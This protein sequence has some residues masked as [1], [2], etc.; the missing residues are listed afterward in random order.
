MKTTCTHP[1]TTIIVLDA[2][3][4]HEI[5]GYKCTECKDIVKTEKS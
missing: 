4:M 5:I 1:T 2:F 3:A